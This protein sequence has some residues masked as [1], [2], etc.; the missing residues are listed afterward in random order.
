MPE[1]VP[2]PVLSRSL[3][4]PEQSR[5]RDGAVLGERALS[6]AWGEGPPAQPAPG[7]PS[8]IPGLSK[9]P[10]CEIDHLAGGKRRS[11]L[12]TPLRSF[13]SFIRHFLTLRGPQRENR[14]LC[15]FGIASGE[16]GAFDWHPAN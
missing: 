10:T 1:K 16:S 9:R 3:S 4:K 7:G 14:R 12:H 13:R 6:C 8:L 11:W 2:E 5:F 15:F